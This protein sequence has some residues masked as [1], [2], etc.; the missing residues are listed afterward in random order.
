MYRYGGRASL[1]CEGLLR[2]VWADALGFAGCELLRRMVRPSVHACMAVH[3]IIIISASSG[4]GSSISIVVVGGGG[5]GV[6]G[7]ARSFLFVCLSS[8]C[9]WGKCCA[10]SHPGSRDDRRR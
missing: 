4:S 10:H 3:H 6:L 2:E 7:I 1:L 9:W 8:R 5:G